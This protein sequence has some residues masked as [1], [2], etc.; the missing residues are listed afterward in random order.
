MK[1]LIQRVSRASVTV[2]GET[3]GAIGKGLLVL[4]GV[5]EH[6]TDT[7]V[8]QLTDKLLKLRIFA[9]SDDKTNC[10]IQ[11]VNGALLVISQFTLCADCRRGTRPSFSHAAKPDEAKRLYELFLSQCRAVIPQVECG[12]FG[13]HMNV[14]LLN[15]GP[16]T[17]MLDTDDLNRP[18][19]N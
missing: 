6:D 2:D 10:S 9:D 17:V 1:A 5:T 19:H 13:A 7:E 18:R 16:F 8:A 12:V 3:V 4:L 14:E 15:D 11:D